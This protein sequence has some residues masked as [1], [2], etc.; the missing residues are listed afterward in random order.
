MKI[1]PTA[2]ACA[3][4]SLLGLALWQGRPATAAPAPGLEIAT[5]AG[6]CFWCM[7]PAFD[8]VPGV[9]Q[10]IVGYTGGRAQNPTYE[11]VSSGSTGH[12]ES[13][14][15]RF[16]PKKVSYDKLLDVFWHNIDPVTAN[17]QFCDHGT[18]YRSAIFFHGEAQHQ[19]AEASKQKLVAAK[20]LPGPI[21]TQ[22]V[23][24][25]K[26]WPAEEY[27]QDYYEKNPLRY[28]FYRQ[29]CGRDRRLQQLWG[30]EAGGH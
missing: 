25:S 30:A 9:A 29:S 14:E 28:N 19:A 6:G 22:I 23:A 17:A 12:A 7:Q 24:A 11:E 15:V 4:F 18:Q 10:T 2:S 13:I 20:K 26:F 16:D 3:L 5:F 8:K 27:H 21:V 1:K